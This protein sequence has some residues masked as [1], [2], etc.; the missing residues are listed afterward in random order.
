MKQAITLSEVIRF[1][2]NSQYTIHINEI[3]NKAIEYYS[4]MN[5]EKTA[6][7]YYELAMEKGYKVD[8]DFIENLS[9]S[10]IAAGMPNKGMELLK[11]L[12]E[13]R[14]GDIDLLNNM[15]DNYPRIFG[16]DSLLFLSRKKNR[17]S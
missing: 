3:Y 5:D 1:I 11:K 15:A 14:P 10:Y 9:N 12:L 4:A 17:R 6:V 8:N 7:K 16:F 13:K 2:N